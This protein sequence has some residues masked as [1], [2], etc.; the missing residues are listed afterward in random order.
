MANHLHIFIQNGADPR[1]FRSP[2]QVAKGPRIPHRDRNLHGQYLKNKFDDIWQRVQQISTQRMAVSLQTREG[3]Y[4]EFSSRA[5][6]DL[7]SKSLEDI[8]KGVR[9]LNVRTSGEGDNQQNLATVYI[10]KG[11]EQFFLSKIEAY[12]TAETQKGEPKNKKLVDSIEDVKL[13]M[14]ESLWTDLR[15]GFGGE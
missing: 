1:Q 9:L 13:A 5:G 11:K 2:K 10:P 8:R 3:T 15:A 6:Y 12:R 14:L 7:I 4:L